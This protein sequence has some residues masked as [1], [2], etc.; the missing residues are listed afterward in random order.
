[1]Q[2]C[3]TPQFVAPEMVAHNRA[4]VGYDRMVDW[5]SLGVMVHEMASAKLPFDDTNWEMLQ[6][7]I[8]SDL[9]VYPES[10]REKGLTTLLNGLLAKEARNRFG[11]EQ[12]KSDAFYKPLDWKA[13]AARNIPAPI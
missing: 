6:K 13:L 8:M 2:R 1:M 4:L 10:I 5:W 12:M 11:L 9:P 7:K 3:G